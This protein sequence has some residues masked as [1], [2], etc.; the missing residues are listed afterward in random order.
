MPT[1]YEHVEER[2]HI[3]G[4][5]RLNGQQGTR[6][7]NNTCYASDQTTC[8]PLV[9]TA[10][11]VYAAAYLLQSSPTLLCPYY[12]GQYYTDPSGVTYYIMCGYSVANP[13][14]YASGYSTGN[15]FA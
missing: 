7:Y 2:A 3:R 15:D 13:H 9:N 6:Y 10:N 11:N 4:S 14:Q 1:S 5:Y 12:N 8:T